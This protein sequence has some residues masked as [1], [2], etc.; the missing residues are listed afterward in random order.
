MIPQNEALLDDW[1]AEIEAPIDLRPPIQIEAV[2]KFNDGE[3]YVLNRMPEFLYEFEGRNLIARDG[4][5]AD[6]LKYEAPRGR[7]KAF[8]GREI[9]FPMLDGTTT[10]GT[11]EYW[12]CGVR[13]MVSATFSTKARLL[14][15]YVFTGASVCPDAMEKLR[16]EYTGDVYPY[17]AYEAV[18][19]APG[20]RIKAL[21]AE[22]RFATAKKHILN[23]LRSI[24][25][26]RDELL[27]FI[28]GG[29]V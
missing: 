4:P 27:S 8:G 2:V 17:Y 3:A 22:Q 29:K 26:E 21:L 20:L 7:F 6:A 15:C 13:G 14:E 24:K 28:R 9:R 25:S 11:G 12:S 19:Q 5:F 18:I 16:S 10:I 1:I 23:N